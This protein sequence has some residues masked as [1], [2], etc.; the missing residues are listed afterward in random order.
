MIRRYQNTR[1]IAGGRMLA[2]PRA[3]RNLQEAAAAG[4]LR[5]RTRIVKVGER[6]DVI[7]GEELGDAR[8]WWMIAAC[9]NIGWGLQVPPG[10]QIYIP[11]SF[12]EVKAIVG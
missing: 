3:A 9:S 7:A 12:A 1:K 4:R 10:T 2:T 11:A 6:L 8:A 5:L